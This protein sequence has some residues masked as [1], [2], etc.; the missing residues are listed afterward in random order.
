M[1]DSHGEM[2]SNQEIVNYQFVNYQLYLYLC[3]KD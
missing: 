2:T 3:A 1:A